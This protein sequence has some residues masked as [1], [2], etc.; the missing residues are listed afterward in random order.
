[1]AALG[2]QSVPVDVLV[3]LP[4]YLHNI[5][6]YTN[7]SSTCRTLRE[8]MAAATPNHILRLA[9]AQSKIFCRPSPD[10]LIAATARELGN[11]ARE[12]DTNEQELALRMEEGVDAL[13]DLALEHCGLTMQCIRELHLLRFSCVGKQWYALPD[14]WNGGA[15]DAYTIASDPPTTFFHLA[16]Y[17]ELFGPD[18]EAILDQTDAR[19]LGV[20][21][22]L[23]YIKYCVPDFATTCPTRDEVEPRRRIKNTGPYATPNESGPRWR[24]HWKAFRAKA[25]PDFQEDFDDGWW[26]D[27]GV[28]QN[29]RQR[30]WEDIMVCQGLEGLGMIRPGSLQ[31]S[32]IPKVK[33]WRDK[34][35]KLER[36][37]AGKS[38]KAGYF[39]IPLSAWGSEDLCQRLCYGNMMV[40]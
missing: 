32:W 37:R 25:G 34:I 31:D 18:F 22:R 36:A 1:M 5:E 11:W 9:A 28:D 12:S 6:D 2:L 14:F 26:Y 27:E 15:D 3:S 17:G 16:T 8:C 35:A 39:R 20:D 21:T 24:P 23:E 7:L 38:W 40:D 4:D 10:F 33:V 19:R 30:L 13:L 29:W